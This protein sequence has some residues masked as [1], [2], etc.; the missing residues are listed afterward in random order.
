MSFPPARSGRESATSPDSL[1]AFPHRLSLGRVRPIGT[2][3][4]DYSDGFGFVRSDR[5]PSSTALLRVNDL[6]DLRGSPQPWTAVSVWDVQLFQRAWSAYRPRLVRLPDSLVT[7]RWRGVAL[8]PVHSAIHPLCLRSYAARKPRLSIR[9]CSFE[10]LSP[11][12]E[13]FL[14]FSS[15]SASPAPETEDESDVG[16]MARTGWYKPAKR[17]GFTPAK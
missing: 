10:G 15:A 1:R 11:S 6:R 5:P 3:A 14:A 12:S 7:I 16:F 9:D 13:L 17:S 4:F 8:N 2:P